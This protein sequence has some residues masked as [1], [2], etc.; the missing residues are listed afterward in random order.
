MYQGAVSP[1]SIPMTCRVTP[2]R[3]ARHRNSFIRPFDA[4]PAHLMDAAKRVFKLFKPSTIAQLA[5]DGSTGVV[6][7]V[8]GDEG[9]ALD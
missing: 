2:W 9:P 1:L 6:P 4:L 3:G 5:S 8:A 7:P